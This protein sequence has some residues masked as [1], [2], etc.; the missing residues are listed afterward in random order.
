M[1]TPTSSCRR[2]ARASAATQ[3][4]RPSVPAGHVTLLADLVG[5]SDAVAATSSRSQKIAI[6]ADLLRSLEPGEVPIA[7]GFLSGVPRQG[8]IGIGYAAVYRNASESPEPAAAPSLT[9]GDVDR[10]I[11]SI[12]AATGSGSAA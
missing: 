4:S 12:E 5:A 8:R 6:L 9:I 10:A 3:R 2:C 7:V 11:D 1:C